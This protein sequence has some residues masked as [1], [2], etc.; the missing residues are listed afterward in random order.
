[1][2][3]QSPS[4]VRLGWLLTRRSLER[5]CRARCCRRRRYAQPRDRP[6]PKI[7]VAESRSGARVLL[8]RSPHDRRARSPQ[9]DH[10]LQILSLFAVEPASAGAAAANVQLRIATIFV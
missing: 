1:M 7:L 4:L 2:L 5:P 9:P 8:R 6:A 10:A 3:E